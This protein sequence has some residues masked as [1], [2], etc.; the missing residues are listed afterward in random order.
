MM[1]EKRLK[2]PRLLD[3][4]KKAFRQIV[5]KQTISG[6]YVA[7]QDKFELNKLEKELIRRLNPK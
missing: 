6:E 5:I 4:Y 3:E 7:T 1:D 2:T